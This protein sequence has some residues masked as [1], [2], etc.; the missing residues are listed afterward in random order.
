[1][2]YA[3]SGVALLFYAAFLTPCYF[4][5]GDL[6]I[7]TG[8]IAILTA[9]FGS[10]G[11]FIAI[12]WAATGYAAL[13]WG[14]VLIGHSATRR[15]PFLGRLH[16]PIRAITANPVRTTVIIFV[17]TILVTVLVFYQEELIQS[18]VV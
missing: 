9:Q 3:L 15:V 2:K 7:S 6:V 10:L 11:M 14:I 18:V 4:E 16:G 17:I 1:M 8:Y 12:I 13:V 5:P